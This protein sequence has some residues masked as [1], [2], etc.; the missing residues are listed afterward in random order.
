MTASNYV[1][2]G[3]AALVKARQYRQSQPGRNRAEPQRVDEAKIMSKFREKIGHEFIKVLPPTIFFFVI[4]HIVALIRALM[5]RGT[6][7]SLASN[8]A[9]GSHPNRLENAR[10]AYS[11]RERCK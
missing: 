4:L 8:T 2:S 11:L 5:I 6:G 7:V 3:Q 10:E 9:V 1:T